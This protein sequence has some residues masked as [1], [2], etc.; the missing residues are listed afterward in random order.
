MKIKQLLHN[1]KF[2]HGSMATI[3]TAVFLAIV[4]LF[5]V[6]ASAV[7]NHYDLSIDATSSRI[8]Q[9][10]SQTEEFLQHYDEKVTIYVLDDEQAF[11][12]NSDL[13]AQAYHLIEKFDALSQNITVKY[14]N[15]TEHPELVSQFPDAQLLDGDVVVAGENGRYQALSSTD[16]FSQTYDYYTYQVVDT[17]SLVEQ[18]LDSALEYVAGTNPV[19]VAII[20]GHE[21]QD[22]SSITPVFER[23]NYVFDSVSLLTGEIKETTNLVLIAAPTVDFTTEEIA[24][25]EAYLDNGGSLG[26]S[27]VYIGAATQSEL[28]NLEAFLAKWGI[29][30]QD[31]LIYELDANA[32]YDNQL[33]PFVY[34]T[35]NEYTDRLTNYQ[36]EV[37]APY[38]K[39]MEIGE[40]EEGVEV[41]S[42]LATNETCVRKPADAGEDWDY[43]RDDLQSYQVALAGVKSN[44]Q[45]KSQVVAFASMELFGYISEP[46]LNN[47]N[48]V[49]NV[50]NQISNRQSS[51][52]VAAKSLTASTLGVTSLQ[53]TLLLIVFIVLVPG[54]VLIIGIVTWL[55][56]RYR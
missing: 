51:V 52:Q 27:L 6:A 20:T 49:L 43:S 39:P 29:D 33:S 18:A 1:K 5:N 24:K 19:N 16:L 45:S 13:Y 48:L 12:T 56:R 55:R 30:V 53:A 9:L 42:I 31:G 4:V 38:L 15:L 21:D 40:G 8:F 37:L 36:L 23:S 28:P 32:V 41:T 25:L 7:I 35:E 14:M 54:I 2:Q 3:F 47:G 50:F 26:K 34:P 22:I 46:V 10:S 11:K 17:Y 44:E